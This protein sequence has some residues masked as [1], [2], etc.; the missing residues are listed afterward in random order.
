MGNAHK[1]EKNQLFF[2]I[3]VTWSLKDG[4]EPFDVQKEKTNEEKL[5][6]H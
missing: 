2:V 4:E 5:L 3:W 6:I 1:K